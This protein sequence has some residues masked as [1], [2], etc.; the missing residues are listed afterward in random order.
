MRYQIGG[1]LSPS[2]P[3]YVE[4]EADKQLYQALKKGD[5]C[6]ILNS[7]QMRKSSLMI[8]TKHRLMEE[9]YRCTTID[10]TNIGTENITPLEWYKGIVADLWSGLNLFGT[11]KLSKWWKEQ[12]NSSPLQKLSLFISNVLFLKKVLYWT[13]GQPFLTQ[14]LCRLL[15]LM[16]PESLKED[17]VEVT[18]RSKIIDNWEAQDEPEHLRT[19]RDR[20]LA[21]T[22]FKGRLLGIYQRIL[23]EKT[24]RVDQSQEQTQLLLSGLVVKE[25]EQL[26]VKNPI[27]RT[28]FNAQWVEQQL[29]NLRPYAAQINAWL[30]SQQ[31][32]SQLLGGLTLKEAL[33]WAENKQLSDI[34]YRFLNASQTKEKQLV[35]NNFNIEKQ[36]REQAQFALE[37][38]KNANRLLSRA[39]RRS[40]QKAR[41]LR[42][43]PISIAWLGGG[44]ALLILLVRL[45]GLFQ[46]AEWMLG[47]LFVQ[48]NQP[49]AIATDYLT[50]ITVDETDLQKLGQFPPS[51]SMITLALEKINAAQPKAI[52]L[53]IYRNLSLE[54]R[55]KAWQQLSSRTPNLIATEEVLGYEII[56]P[57]SVSEIPRQIGFSDRLLDGDGKVRRAVLARKISQSSQ[58]DL[59]FPLKLALKYLDLNEKTITNSISNGTLNLKQAQI[60]FFKNNDANYI[61]A[62][63]DDYQILINYLGTQKQF[64]NYSLSQLL[65]GEVPAADIRNRVVIMGLTTESFNK[66]YQ[67][68][69]STR[70]S[71]VPEEMPGIV[72]DANIVNQLLTSALNQTTLK[73]LSESAEWLWILFWCLWG[74]ALGWMLQSLRLIV[75]GGVASIAVLVSFS[76]LAFTNGWLLP[77]FPCL[78]GL[79]L[80]SKT[81]PLVAAYQLRKVRLRDTVKQI[82]EVAEAQ[83]AAA[84][85]ALENLKQAESDEN[86]A[87]ID[88]MVRQMLVKS[89]STD[90]PPKMQVR[91]KLQVSC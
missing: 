19:V 41:Y 29:N 49:Q 15:L 72:V 81:F 71:N 78:L 6:Y 70:W 66:L 25:G 74:A 77:L 76:Y 85:V 1:T 33:A 67:T 46:G 69:F 17:C 9:G 90:S 2:D 59:S 4:R 73:T 64:T 80:A 26:K 35:E 84:E 31:D 75:V 42:P 61:R 5:F 68:P 48:M 45:S 58:L 21:N 51:D 12:E 37:A 3:F 28:I 55:D 14:K 53:K 7:R 27:Y 13:G 89:Q 56:P 43:H 40:R 10:M 32:S 44:F 39:Q 24:V 34:D 57:K 54:S 86:R 88:K 38:A 11:I 18:V 65:A 52:G 62:A 87:Y 22:P 63:D 8:K 83:P 30:T 23:A 91:D 36:K 16:C 60:K 50:L 79:A 47:D 82:I 20:F